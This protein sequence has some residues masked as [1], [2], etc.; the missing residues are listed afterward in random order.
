MPNYDP[1]SDD[2]HHPP[3]HEPDAEID[4]L[5]T[6]LAE[7]K[8][9]IAELGARNKHM[10]TVLYDAQVLLG[11]EDIGELITGPT[12][13]I[14]RLIARAEHAEARVAE[15]ECGP[16]AK[17]KA[18][19]EGECERLEA[20]IANIN[21]QSPDDAQ[22]HVTLMLARAEKAE[23]RVVELE[24]LCTAQHGAVARAERAEAERDAEMER[25][26]ACEHIA[27]GDD[28]W[29]K[30][31]NLCPSTAAVA[32][33]RDRYAAKDARIQWM[34]ALLIGMATPADPSRDI[35]AETD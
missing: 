4:R 8:A 35:K 21:R 28:G 14:S 29:E 24:A 20:Q 12:G 10:E 19:L 32:R 15:L 2:Y 13:P 23:A 5:R 34:L 25:V 26:K 30:V 31:R 3:R 9:R 18:W 16:I 6:E 22:C 17:Q 27:D 11:T 1:N 33:L 7:A